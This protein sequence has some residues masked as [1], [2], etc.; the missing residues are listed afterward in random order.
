M[1][2]LKKQK[3]PT[4]MFNTVCSA[5]AFSYDGENDGIVVYL[6]FN[7]MIDEKAELR[8]LTEYLISYS[9]V[10]E[11]ILKKDYILLIDQSI[12]NSY[13]GETLLDKANAYV[14]DVSLQ[15]YFDLTYLNESE[16]MNFGSDTIVYKF[17]LK[18]KNG[19]KVLDAPQIEI[20][21]TTNVLS[22]CPSL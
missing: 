22:L 5:E 15:D 10:N 7:Q 16:E 17:K 9:K 3:F 8:L 12:L 4:Q 21:N 19:L 14:K 20:D 1:E 11:Q 6:A 18:F 2:G 13:S